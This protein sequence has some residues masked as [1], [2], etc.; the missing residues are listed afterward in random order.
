MALK[1]DII[2]GFLAN[3]YE[4][5]DSP[6]EELVDVSGI[7]KKD[8]E[9]ILNAW[10]NTSP[11]MRMMIS[12]DEDTMRSW[13]RNN[14]RKSN[15]SKNIDSG[16]FS[17]WMKERKELEIAETIAGNDL[18]KITGDNKGGMTPDSVKSSQAYQTAKKNWNKAFN[19]LREFNRKSPKEFQRMDAANRR[20]SRKSNPTKIPQLTPEYIEIIKKYNKGKKLEEFLEGIRVI[21]E[22]LALG[23]W[24]PRGSVSSG[25]AR[26]L[27]IR[28]DK[29]GR[30]KYLPYSEENGT[31]RT[32]IYNLINALDYFWSFDGS[33]EEMAL[34]ISQLTEK[35]LKKY[36]E[37]Y[38]LSLLLLAREVSDA[39]IDLDESRKLP[40]MT[41]IGLSPRVNYTLKEMNLDIDLPSIRL[42]DIDFNLVQKKYLDPK[43]KET[44]GQ[45]MFN[46]DGRPVMEKE[47]YVKWSPN[48]HHNM[49]RFV[50]HGQCQACGKRIPSGMFV[51][52]E[53]Y[54]KKSHS[55]IS[56]ML[57]QD[58]ASNIFGIKDEGI[59]QE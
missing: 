18:R 1:I 29:E 30:E 19:D 47:Y 55:L 44:Y 50:G 49:G 11:K 20:A 33:D 57:G 7:N 10:R 59:R 51:P 24:I 3:S 31:Q 40:T 32:P 52:V 5:S 43:N 16:E 22:S 39:V 17:A 56:L 9:E 8:A 28:L 34:A 36:P 14:K 12:M 48:I 2:A 4:V 41:P 38:I 53:A 26:K 37:E 25:K 42:A 21:N 15:P 46:R 35:E 13:I 23:G 45:P 27:R 54:D 6:I 58:C